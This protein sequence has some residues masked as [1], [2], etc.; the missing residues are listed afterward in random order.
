MMFPYTSKTANRQLE[1]GSIV[2]SGYRPDEGAYAIA[3]ANGPYAVLVKGAFAAAIPVEKR[4][5][6][7]AQTLPVAE[8]VDQ[9]QR[10]GRSYGNSGRPG[11]GG[12][13]EATGSVLP[14]VEG[15]PS[16]GTEQ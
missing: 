2:R 15:A 13:K 11:V 16:P 5:F 4:D 1:T 3:R 8:A 7:Q 14:S 9:F 10:T 12:T 6:L